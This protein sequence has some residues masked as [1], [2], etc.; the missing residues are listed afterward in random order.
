[1]SRGFRRWPF[2]LFA[3][4]LAAVATPAC[5]LLPSMLPAS[6]TLAPGE[7]ARVG[8]GLLLRAR[9]ERVVSDSRCPLNANCIQAGDATIAITFTVGNDQ[10]SVELMLDTVARRIASFRGYAVE[11]TR[12]DPFPIAGQVTLPGD[13][14]AFI[15]IK[16]D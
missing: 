15:T 9:F 7:T 10:T 12:L 8:A 6:F 5:D 4:L 2:A 13:Y 3:M 14:R 11:F 16:K 1:M